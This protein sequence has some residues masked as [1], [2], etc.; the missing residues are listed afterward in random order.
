MDEVDVDREMRAPAL[1]RRLKPAFPLHAHR[2]PATSPKPAVPV[3]ILVIASLLDISFSIT[4]SSHNVINI[5]FAE[6]LNFGS[7]D[8]DY[9]VDPTIFQLARTL[10]AKLI[11]FQLVMRYVQRRQVTPS[12]C[13]AESCSSKADSGSES[14]FDKPSSNSTSCERATKARAIATLCCSP[15]ENLVRVL[16]SVRKH[17]DHTQF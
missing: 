15:P 9:V 7:S 12:R 13:P 2:K 14:E 17:V 1:Y 4:L 16:V 10:S 8:T 6:A 3:A 5:A 11:S